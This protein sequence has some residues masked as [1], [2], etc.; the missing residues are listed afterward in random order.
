MK[1]IENHE[2]KINYK[3]LSYKILFTEEYVIRSHD[4]NFLKKYGGL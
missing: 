1:G 2:G 3:D 4:I